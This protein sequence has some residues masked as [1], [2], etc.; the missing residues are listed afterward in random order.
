MDNIIET[1]QNDKATKDI[2]DSIIDNQPKR[3]FK[4][5]T[6]SD[7]PIFDIKGGSFTLFDGDYPCFK[8]K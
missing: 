7:K 4:K 8:L 6:T 5:A 1:K 2:T 3:L